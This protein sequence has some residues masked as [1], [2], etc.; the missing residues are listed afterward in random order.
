ML[1]QARQDGFLEWGEGVEIVVVVF[2][3]AFAEGACAVGEVGLEARG[4]LAAG[5]ILLEDFVEH[6]WTV[7]ES[8][9]GFP[10]LRW[11]EQSG[12]GEPGLEPGRVG[13][14]VVAG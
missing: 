10:D 3:D 8:L 12:G 14:D 5:N 7:A 11:V 4:S 6:F 2:P 13:V 9:E 1:D